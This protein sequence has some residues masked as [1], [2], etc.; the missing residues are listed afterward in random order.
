MLSIIDDN[1]YE[2]NEHFSAAVSFARPYNDS[3]PKVSISP[4]FAQITIIDDDGQSL[5]STYIHY[6]TQKMFLYEI[7]V[8]SFGFEPIVYSVNESA[9]STDL[10]IFFNGDPGVFVPHV[11]IS[12]V[13]ITASSQYSNI[14][15][16]YAKN[17]NMLSILCH[18]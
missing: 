9:G 7:I 13:D 8:L 10:H 3:A 2:L 17:I 14:F 6:C 11:N 12:T 1:V 18:R 5:M 4:E 15:S 16:V